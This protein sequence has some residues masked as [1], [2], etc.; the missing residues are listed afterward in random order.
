[1]LW[2]W[3]EHAPTNQWQEIKSQLGITSSSFFIE[4]KLTQNNKN[5]TTDTSL[6]WGK[7]EY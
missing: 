4:V 6:F 3:F 5:P 1:L 2:P 7:K